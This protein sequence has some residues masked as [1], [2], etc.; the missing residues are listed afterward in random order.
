[1]TFATIPSLADLGLDDGTGELRLP[2]AAPLSGAGFLNATA[3]VADAAAHGALRRQ[4]RRRLMRFIENRGTG[5]G[6]VALAALAL[7]AC[8]SDNDGPLP[9]LLG[10]GPERSSVLAVV[11]RGAPRDLSVMC[12]F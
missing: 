8:S 1:M 6:G 3:P 11:P 10:G 2:G 5:L 4:L 9:S 12:A 7:A